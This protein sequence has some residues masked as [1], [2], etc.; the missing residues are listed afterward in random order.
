MLVNC[1]LMSRNPHIVV[2][3]CHHARS[4]KMSKA[5][6]LRLRRRLDEEAKLN[7]AKTELLSDQY[8][9]QQQQPDNCLLEP[10]VVDSE[11]QKVRNNT[12]VILR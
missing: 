2:T 5:D 7:E 3:S 1:E 4:P 10:E 6:G 12:V 9:Q 8:Q 11:W